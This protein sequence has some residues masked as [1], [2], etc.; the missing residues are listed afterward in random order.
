MPASL[1]IP[2]SLSLA[3]SL[4]P[5]LA[6]SLPLPFT[7][8]PLTFSP[9]T[10]SSPPHH[11][12][13]LLS[14][15]LLITQLLTSHLPPALCAL[16]CPIQRSQQEVPLTNSAEWSALRLCRDQVNKCI[17]AARVDKAI[18]ASLEAK[19]AV[20]TDDPTLSEALRKFSDSESANGVD[21]LRYIFLTSQ[22]PHLAITRE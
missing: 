8:S 21:E 20:Y 18:G 10:P 17:E 13:L 16:G 7:S 19:V 1:G 3:S 15:H 14:P 4:P 9:L 2:S 12:P 6:P 5:S 11:S 22:A